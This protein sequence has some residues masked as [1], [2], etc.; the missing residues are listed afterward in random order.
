MNPP[1]LKRKKIR[2]DWSGAMG[3]MQ[4]LTKC[5]QLKMTASDEKMYLRH[6]L[7]KYRRKRRMNAIERVGSPFLNTQDNTQDKTQDNF[8]KR[9]VIDS[10]LGMQEYLP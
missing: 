9:F 2:K 3:V 5:M 4:L 7:I 10:D 8:E 1:L 6:S